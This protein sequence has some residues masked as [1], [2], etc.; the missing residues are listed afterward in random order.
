MAPLPS[1]HCTRVTGKEERSRLPEHHT[2]LV[3]QWFEDDMPL[4]I[5]CQSP[6]RPKGFPS[7]SAVK[8]PTAYMGLIPG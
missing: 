4:L 3:L 8:N 2:L 6:I 1:A 5:I 7:G